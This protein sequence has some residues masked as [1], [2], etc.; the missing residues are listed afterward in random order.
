MLRNAQN[1][2]NNNIAFLFFATKSLLFYRNEVHLR[3]GLCQCRIHYSACAYGSFFF[4]WSIFIYFYFSIF[5]TSTGEKQKRSL[6]NYI[7]VIIQKDLFFIFFSFIKSLK[8]SLR[9]GWLAGRDVKE[10]DLSVYEEG[11]SVSSTAPNQIHI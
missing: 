8:V 9:S 10:R 6:L 11:K 7:T 4:F 1:V 3:C 5:Y 2:C